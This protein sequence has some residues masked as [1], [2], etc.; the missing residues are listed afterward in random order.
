MTFSVEMINFVRFSAMI[1][2]YE[3][4]VFLPKITFKKWEHT[5]ESEAVHFL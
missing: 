4:T 5:F 2:P 3:T 1:F